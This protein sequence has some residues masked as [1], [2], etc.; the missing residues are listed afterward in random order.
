MLS[1]LFFVLEQ[2]IE[3]IEHMINHNPENATYTINQDLKEY[4]IHALR[5]ECSKLKETIHNVAVELDLPKRNISQYQ[6]ISTIQSQMWEN[7][8]D[9]FSDKLKGYGKN[10]VSD[11]KPVDPLIQKIADQIDKLRI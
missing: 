10:L 5:E 2:K 3:S 1:S 9:V 7:I 11:A 8:T 4:E 6:Y